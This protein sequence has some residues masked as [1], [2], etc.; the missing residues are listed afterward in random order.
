MGAQPRVQVSG[1]GGG[2]GGSGTG[3]E[4]ALTKAADESVVN[5]TALQDDN[6]FV[7]TVDAS[8]I[9]YFELKLKVNAATA[10]PDIKMGWSLPAGASVFWYED[11]AAFPIVSSLA[12]PHS[13]ALSLGDQYM[14]YAGYLTIAG[15]AG[16]VKFQWAQNVL[17]A[18]DATTLKKG[19]V[20]RGHKA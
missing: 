11:G 6:D 20:F 19:S 1:G 12:N 8:S 4:F 17:D 7:L 13:Q 16:D 9:Y 14:Y 3:F 5:S 18:T 10:D 15:T 2:G